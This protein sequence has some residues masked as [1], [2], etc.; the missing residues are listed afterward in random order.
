MLVARVVVV[1]AAGLQH[2]GGGKPSLGLGP[3]VVVELE[4]EGIAVE[5]LAFGE[6]VTW[7]PRVFGVLARRG[8]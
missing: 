4:V 1:V 3:V 2:C 7:R 8:K 5:L 6:S